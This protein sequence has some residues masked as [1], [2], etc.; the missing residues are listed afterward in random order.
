MQALSSPESILGILGSPISSLAPMVIPECGPVGAVF[1][2]KEVGALYVGD[3]IWQCVGCTADHRNRFEEW[4]QALLKVSGSLG[5][6]L[7]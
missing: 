4:E 1:L 5:G 6:C 3:H 7:V 2:L